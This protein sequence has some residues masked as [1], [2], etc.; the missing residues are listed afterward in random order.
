MVTCVLASCRGTRQKQLISAKKKH[1]KIFNASTPEINYWVFFHINYVVINPI[2]ACINWESILWCW[3]CLFECFIA[4][5]VIKVNSTPECL[6]FNHLF[7]FDQCSLPSICIAFHWPY[8]IT[9]DV[10]LTCPFSKTWDVLLFNVF[11]MCM[12]WH[13][14][15]NIFPLVTSLQ[16]RSVFVLCMSLGI[17]NAHTSKLAAAS[18]GSVNLDSL[19]CSNVQK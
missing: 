2:C 3:D 16:D 5:G 14:S 13:C 18:R 12:T 4:K 15:Q 7:Q 1:D 8:A 6:V 19:F 10:L 9:Y 17:F 11:L